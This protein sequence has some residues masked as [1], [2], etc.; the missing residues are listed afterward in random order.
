MVGGPTS[1]DLASLAMPLVNTFARKGVC[2]RST[3]DAERLPE[4]AERLSRDVIEP[5][6]VEALLRA[7]ID[8][9]RQIHEERVQQQQE[10][11]V[12]ALRLRDEKLQ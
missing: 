3:R 1:H 6:S 12:T 8:E 7:A 11:L 9:L 4:D 5:M 10:Q 2:I